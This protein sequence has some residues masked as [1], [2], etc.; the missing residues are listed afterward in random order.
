M[1]VEVPMKR[2]THRSLLAV[3]C[4]FLASV[5]I[6]AQQVEAGIFNPSD[7]TLEIRVKAST[8]VAGLP[9]SNIAFTIRWQDSYAVSLGDAVSPVYS[10]SKQGGEQVSGAYRYQKFAAATAQ[11]ITWPE[12]TEISLMTVPVVQ[13]GQGTGSFELIDDAWT[14]TN[15]SSYYVEVSGLD[16][17]GVFYQAEVID[18]PLPLVVTALHA[19]EMDGR[20][21]LRWRAEGLADGIGFGVER[22]R[23]YEAQWETAGIVLT[24]QADS[25]GKFTFIDI[26]PPALA[27]ESVL[28]YRLRLMDADGTSRYSSIV[29]LRPE[30][31]SPKDVYFDVYPNPSSGDIAVS[32][33]LPDAVVISIRIVDVLGRHVRMLSEYEFAQAGYHSRSFNVGD[34][35]NGMYFLVVTRGASASIVP[36]LLISTH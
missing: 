3:L 8:A 17:T 4:L 23:Q 28:Q 26:P 13:S 16:K 21:I 35:A 32:V 36:L 12:N 1:Y 15:N 29:E 19:S 20:V 30:G 34:L 22:R 6:Q 18:V 14:D 27:N 33:S 5:G 25:D 10:L 11:T 24:K 7:S 2:M 9:L 31:V